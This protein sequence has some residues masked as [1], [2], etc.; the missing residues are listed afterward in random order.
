MHAC[1]HTHTHTNTHTHSHTHACTHSHMPRHTQNRPHISHNIFKSILQHFSICIKKYIK[2]RNLSLG[3]HCSVS[4]KS[5]RE[6]SIRKFCCYTRFIKNVHNCDVHLLFQV[7]LFMRKSTQLPELDEHNIL[8]FWV[9]TGFTIQWRWWLS[10]AGWDH[11]WKFEDSFLAWI[12]YSFFFFLK[13]RSA[14]PN[15]PF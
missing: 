15:Q 8:C 5:Y 1:T 9:P 2:N 11:G 10:S 7:L 13:W 3:T 6:D 14:H 4:N 12:I